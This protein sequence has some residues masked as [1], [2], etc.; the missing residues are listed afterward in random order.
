MFP[1][2]DFFLRY[3]RVIFFKSP[4][5]SQKHFVDLIKTHTI[6]FS[7]DDHMELLYPDKELA[8]GGSRN[9]GAALAMN[10][11]LTPLHLLFLALRKA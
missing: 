11:C 1:W 8:P 5:I 6:S 10:I 3:K 7:G 2:P 4:S 9:S